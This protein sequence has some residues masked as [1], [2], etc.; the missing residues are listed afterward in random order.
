MLNAQDVKYAPP[1]IVKK[2]MVT[3]MATRTTTIGSSMMTFP[4]RVNM[5][6][7]VN[8]R[9][10]MAMTRIHGESLCSIQSSPRVFTSLR[11]TKNPITSGAPRKTSTV[12]RMLGMLTLEM[13]N[14][15]LAP[16]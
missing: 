7:R 11:L 14:V 4:L 3:G 16:S 5:T 10:T 1:N 12:M 6:T 13:S 2:K 8:S 9:P 15:A